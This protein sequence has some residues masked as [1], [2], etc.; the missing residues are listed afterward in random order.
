[1]TKSDST[2]S[3][4][5]AETAIITNNLEPGTSVQFLLELVE[6]GKGMIKG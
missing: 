4:P 5:L 3:Q 2:L 6:I 1:M